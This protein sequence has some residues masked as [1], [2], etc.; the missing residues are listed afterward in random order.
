MIRWALVLLVVEVLVVMEIVLVVVVMAGV[1]VVGLMDKQWVMVEEKLGQNHK[2]EQ[3][4]QRQ[5][6]PNQPPVQ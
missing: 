1:V 4:Q 2:R 5:L 6:M 3:Q